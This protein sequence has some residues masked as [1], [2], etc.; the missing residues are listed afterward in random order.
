MSDERLKTMKEVAAQLYRPAHRIIHV[1]ETGVVRP[2]VDAEGR[3]SVRRFSREDIFRIRLALEL[4]DWGVDLPMLNPLMRALDRFKETFEV[5]VVRARLDAV[6]LVSVICEISSIKNPMRAYLMENR[7]VVLLIPAF[8]VSK[9]TGSS[10]PRLEI[11]SD[12]SQ[13]QWPAVTIVANLTLL[14]AEL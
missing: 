5:A 1:C 4:Q 8:T 6:D 14:T 9:R 2:T 3:G 11:I 12:E 7:V 13:I 10:I